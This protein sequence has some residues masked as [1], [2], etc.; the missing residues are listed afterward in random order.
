MR[1]IDE[2]LLRV[3]EYVGPKVLRKAQRMESTKISRV[4]FHGKKNLKVEFKNKFYC[5]TIVTPT[6]TP[7][8][9]PMRQDAR[10]RSKAS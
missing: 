10:T 8:K 2:T 3:R 6:S 9:T 4:C 5:I 7:M 1:K